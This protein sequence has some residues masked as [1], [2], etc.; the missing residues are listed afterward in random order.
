MLPL[1]FLKLRQVLESMGGYSQEGIF[2]LAASQQELEE[3]I[4]N[5]KE[6]N[7]SCKFLDPAV[8]ANALKQWLRELDAPLIE[9]RHYQ[10]CIELGKKSGSL[11][12]A[13]SCNQ[14]ISSLPEANRALIHSLTMMSREISNK[15]NLSSSR[16]SINNLAIIFAPAIL[17]SPD[18]SQATPDVLEIAAK[19]ANE[20]AFVQ[21]LFETLEVDKSLLHLDFW[22]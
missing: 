1:T 22:E 3:Y 7:F 6:G 14:L 13:K 2:R 20:I 10:R 8:P 19:S 21:S 18:D 11:T 15:V 4:E 9:Y 17:R 12:F 5:V 16:M